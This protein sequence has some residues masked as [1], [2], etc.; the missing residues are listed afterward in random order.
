V[1]SFRQ[2]IGTGSGRRLEHGAVLPDARASR[3]RPRGGG[4]AA[5]S[6]SR[7]S[8]EP[9]GTSTAETPSSSAA[10]RRARLLLREGTRPGGG[11]RQALPGGTASP[12]DEREIL[13]DPK[14]QLVVSAPSRTSGRRSASASCA[15]ARTTCGQ[16]GHHDPRAARGGPPGAGGDEAHLLDLLQ[17]AAG[18]PGDGQGGRARE[19]GR[20]RKGR[21][22]VGLGPHRTN[23]AS[24]P[25]WFFVREQY[26]A[27]SAT[28]ASHQFDSS[29]SSPA[30][31]GGGG[32]VAGRERQPPAAPRSRGLRDALVGG[33][34][35]AATIRVDWF[36]PG[37]LKT[38]ATRRA[39]HPRTR[40]LHRD[41]RQEHRPGP[42]ARAEATLFLVDQK[43]TRYVWIARTSRCPT[44]PSWWTTSSTGP[45]PRCRRRTASWPRSWPAGAAKPASG[46]QDLVSR[47]LQRTL[48]EQCAPAAR[49]ATAGSG[50]VVGARPE[51][52]AS[53][54]ASCIR[55]RLDPGSQRLHVSA[56]LPVDVAA[57]GAAALLRRLGEYLPNGAMQP[58]FSSRSMEATLR[59]GSMPARNSISCM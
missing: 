14:I 16:A 39:D 18:E 17:R 31:E 21:A 27:F 23:L 3:K 19:G 59:I 35:A 51:N 36:T 57:V 58:R 28:S 34:G 1:S 52:D 20:H 48:F 6:V 46:V 53:R 30:R 32:G 45:R 12:K 5:A 8:P 38:W 56:R 22:E 2:S 54:S 26:G 15:T 43:E 47:L 40:R 4:R 49:E 24:R 55:C 41:P 37:G 25:A 7:R 33:D 11:L 9:T 13:E 29:S 44:A 10:G 50:T 42:G